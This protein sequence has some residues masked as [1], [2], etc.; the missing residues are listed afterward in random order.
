[1]NTSFNGFDMS[2]GNLSRLSH[3]KSRSISA[4]NRTGEK[5]KG[6]M[7]PADPNGSSREL[8]IGWKNC[9]AVG[10]K[11]GEL[12]EVANIEGPGVIQQIWMTPMGLQRHLILRFYWDD[13]Q[14]PAIECPIGDFFGNGWDSFS[15]ISSLAV[16]ANP[17]NGYN[18]YWSMPFR[19][20]CRITA[21]NI[22]LD[23]IVLFYQ[24]NYSLQEVPDDASY[25]HAQFRRTN[26]LPY[27]TDYTILDGVEGW[28]HY[29]GTTMSWGTFNSGWWGEGEIK[30][31]LDDDKEFPTICGTGTED[32]FGGA[33]CF[34]GVV[35]EGEKKHYANYTTPYSGF[36]QVSSSDF[37][38]TLPR[39]SLY[40]WHI[41]DPVRFEKNLRVT[42]QALG[43]R[44]KNRFLPLQDDIASVAFWYQTHP[45]KPFPKL[46]SRNELEVI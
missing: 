4:E 20:R 17:R 24:V 13:C 19:K 38:H 10:I 41:M 16:C 30:F 1:M 11:P 25:F 12:Y 35:R 2:L 21:E 36:Y 7:A 8:G 33:W 27:Q 28:G 18:C 22:G 43:W 3:A 39:F 6:G 40:R 5:G 15:Q 23:E 34:H 29:V 9:P 14:H 42:M 26:P 37:A 31:Y 45:A 32:Y 44:T 46:P